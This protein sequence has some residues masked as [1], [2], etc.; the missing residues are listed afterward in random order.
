MDEWR[1]LEVKQAPLSEDQTGLDD[2]LKE[3]AHLPPLLYDGEVHVLRERLA[4]A[5]SGKAFVL[6]GGDGGETSD[7][8]TAN[9]ISSRIRTMLQMAAV[10]TYGA[11]M[12]VVKMGR[13]AGQFAKP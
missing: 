8:A 1:N 5:D 4:Q 12:P 13:M 7:G 10:L 11:S 3:L 9:K 2:T 6:Q